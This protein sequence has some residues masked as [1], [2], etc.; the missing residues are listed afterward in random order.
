MLKRKGTRQQASVKKV[1]VLS[2]V[3]VP[4]PNVE[5]VL[6]SFVSSGHVSLG[7][8][9]VKYPVKALRDTDAAQSFF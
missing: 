5:P 1:D 7:V 4:Q 2:N 3:S 9:E 8:D 6:E